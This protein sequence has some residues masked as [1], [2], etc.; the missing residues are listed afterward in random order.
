[1]KRLLVAVAFVSLVAVR[2]GACSPKPGKDQDDPAGKKNPAASLKVGDPAP[3]LKARQW[4]QGDRVTAF[5]PGK[6][7]VV[8]FWATWC[9]SCIAFMPELAALQARYKGQGVT[10]ISYTARDILG[11]PGNT[12]EKVAAFVRKRGPK[13]AYA[14]AYADDPTA[15]DAWMKAAGREAIPCAFLVD[16]TGRIAYIGNPMYLAVAVPMALAGDV[17][18]PEIADRVGKIAREFNAACEALFPDHKVGLRAIKEFEAK[19]PALA[20]HWIILRPKLR[21]LPK[22]GAV[23]EAK[24]VAE[25]AI[26]KAIKQDNLTGLILVAAL[27]RDGPGKGS[28]ELLAVAVKAAEAAVRVAGKGDARALIEL[29]ST[30]AAVGDKARAEKYARKAVEAA[31]GESGELRQ[32]ITQEAKGLSGGKREDKK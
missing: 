12:K 15:P 18:P 1:M 29:A 4:L 16:K 24:R 14:F 27:L 31:A 21:L 19:Y 20:N 30:Y 17:K 3:P 26:A 8:E 22:I 5:E 13:L 32:S 25:A 28:K 11:V 9:G 7:Y 6:V 2:T 10:C 23:D